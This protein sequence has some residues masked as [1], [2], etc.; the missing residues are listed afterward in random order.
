MKKL[1]RRMSMVPKGLRYKLMIS[2]ALMSIIPLLVCVYLVST[3]IFPALDDLA[4]VSIIVILTISIALLGLIL[5]KR[6]VDPIIDMALETRIIASGDFGK[7]VTIETEDEVGDIGRSI[8][9]MTQK[10]KGY[11]SELQDYSVR[12]KEVN[13]EIQ[14][15][16][17]ALSNL[18][19]IGDMIAVS[20][21]LERVYE[22]IVEKVNDLYDDNSTALFLIRDNSPKLNLMASS[23]IDKEHLKT[24]SFNLGK[25]FLG[26]NVGDKK[27]IK[28][29]TSARLTSQSEDICRKF[30]MRNCAVVPVISRGSSIG[31][32]FTGNNT[33]NF[34][35]REDDIELIKVLSKQLGI[36]I[37]NDLLVRKTKELAIKD[38]LTD[39]YNN[40]YIKE[41]LGEE[42]KRAML[43]QRP[44][45][46]LLFD[47]DNFK[48]FRQTQGEMVTEDVLKKIAATLKDSVTPV[49]K[50][51]RIGGD[52]FA[53]VLPEKNKKEATQLAEEI[54]KK[55][56]DIGIKVSKKSKFSLT[57]SGSV[58][59]NPIDGISSKD[60][61]E[62]ATALMK[63]A[64]LE[65][66]N[67]VAT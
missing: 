55:V 51:A 57:I 67:R 37:G 47:I 21:K 38:E 2:F 56:E 44:C 43:Y 36:A 64:K 16:V 5:A 10:I 6:M 25:E 15:K 46:L 3:F 50:V 1:F 32:I 41:R 52:E 22:I 45:S 9:A 26:R 35:F 48:E 66:K 62:K 11:M 33:D 14:K 42:I 49:S 23:N 7:R 17:L 8:N 27:V 65:G 20:E 28:V 40:K 18:L 63:R 59:E 54:R 53:V 4:E 58:S 24:I 30:K 12:T 31:F 61:F 19:Q 34:R 39:L 13:L 60:L 29:D